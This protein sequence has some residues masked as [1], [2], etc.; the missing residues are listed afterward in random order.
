[1]DLTDVNDEDLDYTATPS[2]GAISVAPSPV[3]PITASTK[4]GVT[5]TF[6]YFANGATGSQTITVTA[7]DNE[8]T[9][10]AVVTYDIQLF[11]I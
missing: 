7:D 6:T 10:P 9:F 8:A 4:N 5:V 2:T 3:S 11:I 1:F